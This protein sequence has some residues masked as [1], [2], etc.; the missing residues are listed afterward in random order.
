VLFD[1]KWWMVSA[2]FAIG[3]PAEEMAEFEREGRLL[4]WRR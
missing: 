2:V 1:E 3:F 4:N